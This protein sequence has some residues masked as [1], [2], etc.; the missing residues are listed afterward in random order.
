[1]F[2]KISYGK[3]FQMIKF[4]NIMQVLSKLWLL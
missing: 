1:M 2:F 4:D 3:Y